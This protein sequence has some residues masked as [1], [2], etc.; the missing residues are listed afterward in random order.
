MLKSLWKREGSPV[1]AQDSA[2]WKGHLRTTETP[3][4]DDAESGETS[5]GVLHPLW[6]GDGGPYIARLEDGCDLAEVPARKVW[7]GTARFK[8]SVKDEI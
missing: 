3:A 8:L 5:L 2:S 4:S 6:D 1:E 7:R